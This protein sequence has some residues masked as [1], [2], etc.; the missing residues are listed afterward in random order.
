MTFDKISSHLL[1]SSCVFHF[2]KFCLHI[3]KLQGFLSLLA[4]RS[5][6]YLFLIRFASH[7]ISVVCISE[8][9]FSSSFTSPSRWSFLASDWSWLEDC[10]RIV[11]LVI[12]DL[13]LV[14]LLLDRDKGY[15][16]LFNFTLICLVLKFPCLSS[17]VFLNGDR[18]VKRLSNHF[19]LPW[20]QFF[21]QWGIM[22]FS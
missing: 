14:Q 18:C 12:Y 17:L 7:W 10:Y 2:C 22:L 11:L 4:I 16:V 19:N 6:L 1:T 15:F 20:G 21:A 13:V 9:S 5:V 8:D 3:D